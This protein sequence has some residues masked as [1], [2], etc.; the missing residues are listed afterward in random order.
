L[1]NFKI[2]KFGAI[3]FAVILVGTMLAV[4]A[5]AVKINISP[6]M[7]LHTLVRNS[8]EKNLDPD[9]Y[10]TDE[11][12]PVWLDRRYVK[13]QPDLRNTGS[14][15]DIGYN[16]DAGDSIYGSFILYAGEPVDETIPGQGRTASLGGGDSQDW[17]RFSV[18]EGQTISVSLSS[19]F[20][21]E[22]FDS[23]AEAIS[24][25]ATAEAS[26]YYYLNVNEGSGDYTITVNL[27][28]QNDG[29]KGSDAGNSINNA[30]SITPGTYPGY[31]SYSD[32]E[33]WYSFNANSGQGIFVDLEVFDKSDYDVYLYNPSGQMVHSAR[34][35][36]DDHLEYPANAGGT[37]KI[38]INMFPGWDESKWPDNYF[39]YGS[40][41]YTLTLSVGGSAQSPPGPIPQPDVIPV[42]QEFKITN[43]PNSNEDEYSFLA[44]VPNAVYKQGGNQYVSPVV[45]TGDSTQTHWFGDADDTTNYL[46][47]D[48]QTYLD[49][50]GYLPNVIEVDKDPVKAAANLAIRS[51]EKA[52]TAI[53]TV[54]GS[55]FLD[56]WTTMID[57]DASL[58]VK[59]QTT[60]ATPSD[61]K[62]IAGH[63]AMQMWIG[64]DWG[65]MTIYA[66]G[67]NCPSVGVIT[68]RFE[69]GTEEDWPHPYDTPGDNTNIYFPIAMPGL[70]FPFV[71]SASGFD[72]LE[73]TRYS[74]DR[75][76]FN[77]DD[78]DTSIRVTATTSSNSYLEVFLVDPT[79]SVRRPNLPSWNGGQ[80]KPI[81]KWNGD[82]H[83][84]FEDWRRWQPDASTSH[85]VELN[86]PMTGKWSIIVVPHY[87]YG[88]EKSSDS[89]DYHIKAELRQHEQ[90]RIDAGQSAANAAVLASQMHAPFLYVTEDSTPIE[91]KEALNKLGVKNAIF[92]NINDVSKANIPVPTTE[93]TDMKNVIKATKAETKGF[94]RAANQAD[95]VIVVTSYGTE[96]GNF[97]PAG[98]I[99]A[100]H[101][102]NVLNIGEVP[103]AY[104]FLDKA[105]SFRLYS[106]GWYH[107]MRATGYLATMDEPLNWIDVIKDLLRGEFPELGLEQDLRWFGTVYDEIRAWVNGQGLDG[108]GQEAFIFV[109]D[110]EN[111]IRLDIS[112]VMNGRECYAGHI[113][114]DRPSLNAALI[115][116]DIL[117]PAII[118]ANPGRDVTTSQFMNFP[119]GRQWTTNDGTT[120]N[121][122]STRLLKET[123]SSHGRF[124]EGHCI[125]ENWLDRINYGAA[126]NYYS[127]HGT[128]GSGISCQ[129]A[130]VANAFPDA[131]LRHEHLHDFNW[132]DGWRGY[133][134]D[135]Q[136]TSTPRDGGFTWYNAKEPNLYDIIHFKWVD[137]LLDNLHSEFELWMSCTTAQHFGPEIYLEHGSAL[138]YGNAAT[139]LCPQAD[140]L[141]DQWMTDMF[142]NGES[143]GQAFSK[144]VWLHERDYTT[145]DATSLYGSSSLSVHNIQCIYGDPT[146]TLYS[147]EWIE[148]EPVSP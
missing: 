124:Y 139:G 131:E 73:V 106:G 65:A 22:L 100:Y 46:L 118:Y 60:T 72:R 83:N 35:Y 62:D 102:A 13:P 134:Y 101:G 15:K 67:S 51:F 121:V 84:G 111:D 10:T 125:W 112:R 142:V 44:A 17:Y 76:K 52:D 146:M 99:A 29:N 70:Y 36:G 19:G 61:L 80:I 6:T 25:G 7:I 140:L 23:D 1:N 47:D 53:V 120:H 137:Q 93:I 129:F 32:Q 78:T 82:H 71:G 133:M 8:G 122:Y 104:N 86:Y 117:Y 91:T 37:W 147:P 12:Q 130:N 56:E 88:Q 127:G 96:D 126:A 128:G 110:R 24:N 66:R 26:G 28:G 115:N 16:A 141:D 114:F 116:R 39:L 64:K 41:P 98:L 107:G 123:F 14:H 42:A 21:F 55:K 79:G 45:Y 105:D 109:A 143:V 34:Y 94:L 33:D 30:M 49:R 148:P 90:K 87:P 145:Q 50:H 138:Y 69:L 81:H 144:Y 20:S 38:Q 9:L 119:D 136:Q 54:D 3:V 27:G 48:W 97:A 113:P 4:P 74:C 43:D 2:K 40:G 135:D 77:V 108:S 18:A 92:V 89:V 132:W 58:N 31:L 103:D 63:D 57:E 5:A 11:G 59:S 95:D 85:T 68:P 75:Y